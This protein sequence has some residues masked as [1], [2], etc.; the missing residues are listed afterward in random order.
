M[1]TRADAFDLQAA[2]TALRQPPRPR[3]IPADVDY[4]KRGTRANIRIHS[5][6]A[7]FGPC[8]SRSISPASRPGVL[9]RQQTTKRT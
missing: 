8:C 6:M 2:M 1:T 7:E 5:G 9:S 4:A 3:A